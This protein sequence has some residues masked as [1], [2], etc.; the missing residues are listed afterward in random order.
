MR[1]T[2]IERWQRACGQVTGIGRLRLPLA[3][4]PLRVGPDANAHGVTCGSCVVQTAHS[5]VEMVLVGVPTALIEQRHVVITHNARQSDLA[6]MCDH[7]LC[8][9]SVYSADHVTVVAIGT[10][11]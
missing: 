5:F 1:T 11:K 2:C 9:C 3:V 4:Q 8:G 10:P 7:L 6:L